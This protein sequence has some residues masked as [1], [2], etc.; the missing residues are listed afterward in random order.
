MGFEHVCQYVKESGKYAEYFCIHFWNRA[1]DRQQLL[2]TCTGLVCVEK[3][4]QDRASET[5]CTGK[6]KTTLYVTF[7]EIAQICRYRYVDSA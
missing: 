4:L 2:H 5:K 7:M 1:A 3:A 6:L